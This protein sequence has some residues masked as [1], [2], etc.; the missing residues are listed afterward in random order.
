MAV[1]F[2]PTVFDPASFDTGEPT[3]PAPVAVPGR[4][5]ITKIPGRWRVLKIPGRWRVT[6]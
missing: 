2:D 4:W 6:E 1:Y 3:D 5:A